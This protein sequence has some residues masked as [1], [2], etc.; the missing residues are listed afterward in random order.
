V[1]GSDITDNFCRVKPFQ[2]FTHGFGEKTLF[3]EAEVN[4]A[5]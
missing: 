2:S 1:V 5:F 4:F 3:R